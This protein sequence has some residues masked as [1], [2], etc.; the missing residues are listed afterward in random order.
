[1]VVFA[2]SSAYWIAAVFA[3][4]AGLCIAALSVTGNTYVVLTVSDELRGRVFTAL[5][6]VVRVSLLVSMAVVAPLG[7]LVNA[8]IAALVK[9]RGIDPAHVWLSGPRL[10]LLLASALVL[11]AAWNGYRRLEWRRPAASAEVADA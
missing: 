6:A 5:D 2:L 7:D 4:V 11:A 9:S 8:A 3:F 10:T 1:M